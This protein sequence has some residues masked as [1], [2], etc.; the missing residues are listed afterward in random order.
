[1][2]INDDPAQKMPLQESENV[3][4]KQSWVRWDLP[5]SSRLYDY[6]VKEIVEINNIPCKGNV[7]LDT[8]GNLYGF[9]FGR[10]YPING[11]L[12]PT[13]SRYETIL[14]SDAKMKG[15]M[16]TLSE[17]C[18]VQGYLVRHKG[19]FLEDYHIDFYNDGSL[20]YF[21]PVT[22]I[23]IGG[24]PCKG[25]RTNSDISLYPDGSLWVCYLSDNFEIEGK[26]RHEGSQLIFDESGKV[27]EYS[28]KLYLEIMK[29]LNIY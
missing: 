8:L 13:G 5:E 10:D 26:N 22:N 29:R 23:K 18:E 14:G 16:I 25:G 4:F 1:M 24:I 11:T 17:E 2:R 15:Y 20:R 19:S 12:L 9:V 27:H 3:R 7:T 21:K 6:L 28:K